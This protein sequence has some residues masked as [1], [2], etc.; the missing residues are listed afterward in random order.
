MVSGHFYSKIQ[1]S[2]IQTTLLGLIHSWLL[3]IF[4]F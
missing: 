1:D 2:K 4:D 3:I